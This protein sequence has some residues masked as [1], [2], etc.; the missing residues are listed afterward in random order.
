MLKSKIEKKNGYP[1]LYV[2]G[3]ETPAIAYTTYF[4]ER[5]AYKSFISHGYRM[6]FI[7]VSFT[8]QPMNCVQTGFT[9]FRIGVFE[10][11]DEPDYSELDDAARKILKE[12][13]EALIIPRITVSMPRWWCE[14]HPSDTA[15]TPK[16][17]RREGLYS[18]AFKR[19][20]AELVRKIVDHVKNSDYAHRVMGW[21][22]CGGQTQEWFYFD[23]NGSIAD[24]A[25]EPYKMFCKETYGIEEVTLPSL[26]DFKYDTEKGGVDE[27]AI[28]Y[29]EFCNLSVAKAI[30]HFAKTIKEETNFEQIVGTFY[31]YMFNVS[32]PTAGTHGL[33]AIVNSKNIDF[34]S[35]PCA[36]TYLRA[37]G[38]DWS[39]MMPVDSI[40]RAGKLPFIEC[41]IRTYLTTDLNKARPGGCPE[42]TYVTETE[43]GPTVWAGPKTLE[44][45]IEALRKSF[46]HQLCRGSAI[47]WFDMWGG[48]YEDERLMRELEFMRELYVALENNDRF[49][50]HS[51]VALFG[52]ER[53]HAQLGLGS[54][55]ATAY[56]DTR[57]A[58]GNAGAPYDSVMVEDAEDILDN[59]K[60]ALFVCPA[61][62]EAGRRAMQLCREKGIPFLTPSLDKPRYTS[63]E[64]HEFLRSTEVHIYND[65]RDVIYAGNGFVGIHAASEGK[66]TIRLP[67]AC[68]VRAV[69]GSDF[70]SENTDAITIELKK[71]GTALFELYN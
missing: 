30:D 34:F 49:E 67:S 66:K 6:F 29:A 27:N 2:E 54:P 47:W 10:N 42:G 61:A 37:F 56:Q 3:V 9:P 63:D 21:Q 65:T 53:G 69:F 70:E 4:E 11:K 22:L 55:L 38:I 13:P 52:D 58:L 48:W 33:R 32:S 23:F 24:A 36:Y 44:L 64:V 15:D 1:T 45:S 35:S 59:Y 31:G 51:E 40:K 25:Y 14:S 39:D 50:L 60:A 68:R 20:G 5:S 62:S 43:N 8:D 46:V 71:S 26:E 57:I 28:R 7:N 19:D 17:G 12:C 16:G 18:E 41:D